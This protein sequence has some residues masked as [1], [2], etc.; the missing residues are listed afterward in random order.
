VDGIIMSSSQQ[1]PAQIF[2]QNLHGS[3]TAFIIEAIFKNE[4]TAHLNHLV[5]L[6][7]AEEA[8]YFFNSVESVTAAM[9][10]FYFPSSFKTP[11][12]FSLLNPSHVMLRTEALTKISMGGNKKIIVSYP[13]AIFEKV[14][15][16]KT[17][18]QNII[19]LKTNDTLQLNDLMQQLV[20][21]G[22]ERT[23]FVYELG[24]FALRG[25]IFDIYSFGNEKPYRIELFGEE[26]DSI[27]LFDPATQLSERKLLQVNIIP[28]VTTQFEDTEKIPLLD[29]LSK[30]TVVWLKDWDVIKQ[31]GMYQAEALQ[32]FIDHHGGKPK[33]EENDPHQKNTGVDDFINVETTEK[34][35]AAKS[36]IEFGYQPHLTKEKINFNTQVQPAFNR[37]FPL[38]IENLQS[39]EQKG[40]DLF[41]F[42]EQA[43][44]LERLHAIFTDLKT[45]I[46]FTPI[47]KNI[48]EGFIDHEH[49]LLCY[50]DHQIF[51]RYHKYK[52]KQAYT[53]SKAITL[54]TLRD[55]APGDFVTHI[56]HGV[57]V[58]SGLQKM[59]VKGV[60]QEAV[61]IIYKDSDILYVN[62]NSL[63]KI[64]K[65]TGKEGAPPKVNKLGSDAWVKLKDKTK[66]RV[67]TIAFDLIKLYAQ[68]KA[69]SGFAF[70]PDNYMMHELEASF[71]YED[72][73]DQAKA[74]A[75]VK[76]DMEQA[77]PMDRLVCG[78]VGFGKTEVAIRAAFKAAIDGKQ[79]AV[80]VPTTILAFQH[81]KTFKERLK[82]LPVTVDYIN[83][84]KTAAQ[85]K[86]TIQKVKE[87]TI[88]ILV[89]THGILGKDVQFKDLGLMVID[90]EQKF[91]VGHKEKLKTLRTTVDCLTL[92]ATP[93]PRTLH[94]S[95]MGARD[96]SI[97]NTAPAN[98]QPIHTEVQVFHEDVIR[99]TIYFETERGGQV[100]FIHNRVQGLAE[101]CAM[102]QKLC[103]DLSI[104]YAHG[105]LEGHQLEEKILD[106][107]ER[108]YDVLVCTNIVESG[109][110][111]PNVNTII[112][113]NAHQFGLSDLHQLRGRVGRSNKKAFCYLLAPPISTLPDDSRKRL[114]TL[115]QFSELG[116]G[117]QI[118]MRDL[119]IRGA[120][121]LL[122]GEQS[123]F[124]VEIGFEMY[125]KILA[126]AVRELKRSD[127]KELFQEEISQQDDFV[128]DCT[129][130]TDL[131]IMIP[132]AY[133]ENIGERLSLYTRLDQSENEE[134]LLAM[135]DEMTDRFGPMPKSVA[136]L[137]ET[138][139]S[140]KL[141]IALG[142]EKM[143]LKEATLRCYFI[144]RP[145][146]PYF[147]SDLFKS[148][149]A[150]T[151]TSMNNAH[152][153]QVGKLFVLV[154]KD[155]PT[156][157]D[158]HR[159]L[160]KMYSG[161]VK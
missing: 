16:P 37:Q 101:M 153:K 61:R 44:Q 135:Q 66:A 49:K 102:I 150:F 56:D 129:I 96:L 107:I 159:V 118:A 108:R 51:Q 58:Y 70:T 154:I 67:K 133:V 4:A 59:D 68:R 128:Q 95:L 149:L 72:T 20:D 137:F 85:K 64:S 71:I 98:R 55:L 5:V 82:D 125:Q 144:N 62:I 40:Y 10:L 3:S 94:F 124:M 138:V 132:D 84:F 30:D 21:Y 91:G 158:C 99:E 52:V 1:Q 139:R 145:D 117:F 8:A 45:E 130:D 23:D 46:Q 152:F 80:L 48:H 22:F 88:D 81:Y 156:M 140:R 160:Q 126:E 73:I 141:A 100:F 97:I 63:H 109:V 104:G 89:G 54:R 78:D 127:F 83:R 69:Q 38:L 116:S 119:D 41:I 14:I 17:L 142:F 32:D 77:S 103:P 155:V 106:F 87:G 75:D 27:R 39:F 6:N 143:T 131:E 15:L 120:G 9:D 105:Q 147:E 136:D 13:E 86:D 134:E 76:K 93:I 35:L 79:V 42:A 12:N 34:A 65:Y 57:G 24:Q 74:I 43:K 60:M 90:E 36:I 18:Q 122:G 47:V 112:V 151:Q 25:G 50:T 114:Q 33:V 110:D 53:K 29:F 148:L 2:L 123:G 7:D 161:V 19:A 121:N 31:K 113:N 11:Q 146:S 157:E 111:I 115:E 26:V 28:N 92:T